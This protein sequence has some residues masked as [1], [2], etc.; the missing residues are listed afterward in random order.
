VAAAATGSTDS[1]EEHYD[2]I[3]ASATSDGAILRW[4]FNDI[5]ADSFVW[6]GEISKDEGRTWQVQGENHV[7]RHHE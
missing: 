1:I 3:A 6:R 2:S 4:S 5:K 7:H